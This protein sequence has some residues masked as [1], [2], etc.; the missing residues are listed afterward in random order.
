MAAIAAQPRIARS[1]RAGTRARSTAA[2][3]AKKISQGSKMPSTSPPQ[4]MEEQ[5]RRAQGEEQGVGADETGLEEAQNDRGPFE[6]HA[7]AVHGAIH[8]LLVPEAPEP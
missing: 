2:P 1:A 5:R 8:D 4:E 6:H 7:D 3:S